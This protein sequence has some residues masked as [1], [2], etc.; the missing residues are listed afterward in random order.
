[1]FVASNGIVNLT[2]KPCGADPLP[3]RPIEL[4][5]GNLA[6]CFTAQEENIPFRL[7]VRSSEPRVRGATCYTLAGREVLAAT[8]I[9]Q[10]DVSYSDML[11]PLTG[12]MRLYWGRLVPMDGYAV[13]IPGAEMRILIGTEDRQKGLRF[14]EVDVTKLMTRTIQHYVA[15]LVLAGR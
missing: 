11:P 5:G 6:W 10:V 8:H 7:G 9:S 14:H 2:I 15:D 12:G 4:P 1:M 3:V 13:P